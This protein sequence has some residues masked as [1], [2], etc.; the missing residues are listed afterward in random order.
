L[1]KLRSDGF[2]AGDHSDA[3]LSTGDDCGGI[4]IYWHDGGDDIG[5]VAVQE[6]VECVVVGGN[7]VMCSKS[8]SAVGGAVDQGDDFAIRVLGVGMQVAAA[9]GAGAADYGNAI[10]FVWHVLSDFLGVVHGNVLEEIPVVVG[11]GIFCGRF[12]YDI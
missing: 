5:D 9:P 3:S 4:G 10:L 8:L 2:F 12:F 11:V 7:A 6:L 1:G